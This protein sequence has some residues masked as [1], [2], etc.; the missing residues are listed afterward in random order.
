MT[1]MPE[2]KTEHDLTRKEK[3]TLRRAAK[4]RARLYR[5]HRLQG[6]HAPEIEELAA[7]YDPEKDEHA[8]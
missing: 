3:E 5:E 2:Q 7:M 1:P 8:S 4:V 6:W